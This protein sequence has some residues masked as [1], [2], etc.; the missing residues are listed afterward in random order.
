MSDFHVQFAAATLPVFADKQDDRESQT[1]AGFDGSINL[2]PSDRPRR[3]NIR[4]GREMSAE[5]KAWRDQEGTCPEILSELT[6]NMVNSGSGDAQAAWAAWSDSG[7]CD[8]TDMQVV[9]SGGDAQTDSSDSV[10]RDETG[11]SDPVQELIL[12]PWE[13]IPPTDSWFPLRPALSSG[14]WN[15]D[16][17][18]AFLA[19]VQDAGI[20]LANG[21]ISTLMA[22]L[23]SF[24]DYN[25]TKAQVSHRLAAWR[26]FLSLI[27]I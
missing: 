4:C 27:H 2:S 7:S 1:L 16:H 6:F 25:F 13:H 21:T 3:V 10:S 12:A 15:D 22:K 9:C 19:V 26:T 11:Y 14:E 17:D 8:D 20:K 23:N 18:L 5:F 24:Q